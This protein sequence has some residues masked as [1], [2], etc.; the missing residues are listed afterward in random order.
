MVHM[1]REI[2]HADQA[3]D[4]PNNLSLYLLTALLAVI[5]G[6]DLWPLIAGWGPLRSLGL[7]TW[8][9]EFSG[10][11]IALLA[12][13]LGGAR[14]LYTSLEG[15]FEGKVGADLAIA[16]A[17]I[18]A[19]L[20]GEPLVAAEVVFIGM[21]GECLE[22][23]TFDRTQRAVRKLV[24][25]FP[26]RCWLLRDGQEVRVLTDQVQVGDTVVV[27]PGAHMPVDGVVIDGR[28]ALDVS[29]LTGE[30]MTIDKGPGDD[31]LAGSL[32]QF[33]AL[34]VEARRVREQ[35]VAGRVIELTARALKDKAPLERTADRLARYFLPVVLGLALLTF[36]VALVYHHTTWLR[37]PDSLRL[38]WGEAAR[39][40]VYPTLSVLVVAC[41]CA[42]ILATPAAV[43]AA[44]GRLAGTGI[45]I[46]GGSA[47]ER[48]A[49]VNTIAFDKTGTLTEGRLELG[50]VVGLNGVSADEVLQVAATA[51]QRSE[52]VLGRLIVQQAAAHGWTAAPVEEFLA[53]PGAGV[54]ARAGDNTLVVGTPRLLQE[55]G[56]AL[57]AEVEAALRQLDATGQTVLLVARSGVVLGVIGARDRVRPEAKAVVEEL[58]GLG[59]ADIV[60]LTGDRAEATGRVAEALGIAH[61]HAELLP[62]QKAEAVAASR[63]QGRRVAMVGDGINDAPAL[64]GADVGLA[65]SGTDVAAEAGDIVFMG[66]PLRHLPLL[67]RLSRETVRIIR[68]NILIFAFGVN[69]VGILVTAWLWPLLAPAS[70]Y[71]E[72]PIAAVIYHQLGSLAVLLNAMRLLAFERTSTSPTWQRWRAGFERLNAWAERSLDTNTILHWLGHRWKPLAAGLALLLF[73][74]YVL[75]GLTQ[76]ETGEVAVVRQ[77]GRPLDNDLGPGIYWRWP[78]PIEQVTRVRPEEVRSIEIG[79]RSERNATGAPQ[80]MAWSS[81]HG[82]D[83]MLR[84]PDEAVMITGDGNLVELLAT[85][86]YRIGEPRVYLFEVGDPEAILRADAESVLR[87]VVAGRRFHELLTSQ[88]A[89]LTRDVLTRLDECCR[90]HGPHGLG[91]RLDGL[92]VHDLHP[93]QDVVPYYYEVT[94][95]MEARDRAINQA[96]A[97]VLYKARDLGQSALL[98][99]QAEKDGGRLDLSLAEADALALQ[100]GRRAEAARAEQVGAAD[101]ARDVFLARNGA[102]AELSTETKWILAL[103]AIGEMRG[104]KTP[105]NAYEQYK[106]RCA[107][108]LALQPGLTD[109]RLFWTALGRALGGREKIIIDANKVPG[110]LNMLM[111]DPEQFKVP[112][113]ILAPRPMPEGP[114]EGP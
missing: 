14:T 91:I 85:V 45:L 76:V 38:G 98:A 51:E 7:P 8:P 2:S 60:L 74:G 101:S 81:S 105:A 106:R 97:S 46:K 11:R 92:A 15:L 90:Q 17:A 67:M 107:E 29:A 4:R 33:G 71:S 103:D 95:A 40:A 43:I 63:Q 34:T 16:I 23:I 89:A 94:R 3:F 27:K 82:G 113:P 19:I 87:E 28:S 111:M 5:I 47:L 32:N 49:Q 13:V 41:P 58:R 30:T 104:G 84:I 99:A 70:W 10:Y 1:H 93:P 25:V 69:A 78:W 73:A 86:R 64:A 83:G 66:D 114:G 42:L 9:R 79:F 88:R 72:G 52:H 31:V 55:Q 112:V 102:R 21:L 68:Q 20:I 36:L 18:A 39:L 56:I 77:F 57:T 108:Q 100:M 35:T 75:S 96:R 65:I 61:V 62:Q 110:R 54:T 50:D 24:E 109:F 48:L 26:R 22:A 80:G 59:I 37:S 12:A 6:I 53:H 44:L